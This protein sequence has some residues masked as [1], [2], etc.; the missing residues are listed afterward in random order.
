MLEKNTKKIQARVKRGRGIA[1][2]LNSTIVEMFANGDHFELG[3]T[4]RKAMLIS[5]LLTNSEAWYGLKVSEIESLES[6]DEQ[7]MRGLLNANRM[8][9]KAL[10]Y[11][12]LGVVPIRYII[13]ARRLNFLHY[14]LSQK[15]ESLIKQVFNEQ[16]KTSSKNDWTE[17]IKQDIKDLNINKGLEDIKGMTKTKFKEL[18]KEKTE[19]EA[20]KYLKSKIKT[21]GE[22]IAY[23]ILEMQD[24]LRPETKL[25]LHEKSIHL[26]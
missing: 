5:S 12:E 17:Q 3:V 7:Y 23:N 16:W 13:K 2:D 10:L 15:E 21:K 4:L 8:T 19:L 9:N 22:E 1:K 26:K 18:V 6:V 25:K 24:Y 14:I 11:L 20:L